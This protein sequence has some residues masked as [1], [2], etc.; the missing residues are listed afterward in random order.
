MHHYS[1][2]EV[3]ASFSFFVP[4][5]VRLSDIDGYMHV[6]N[7]IYFN[8]FEHARALFLF[9]HCGWYVMDIGTVVASIQIDYR[10]PIHAEDN[11][12]VYVRCTEIGRSSFVLE[13]VIIAN[14]KEGSGTVY[15]QA[16]TTMVAV[17]L[18]LMRP[19]S[20]PEPYAAK[21]RSS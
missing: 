2:E 6:N 4:I 20:V 9:Q 8:Y 11:P 21:L 7:G 14:E 3:R 1:V 15:A 13:Q 12:L 10:K 18:K 19:V 16:E 5:Q 17:D